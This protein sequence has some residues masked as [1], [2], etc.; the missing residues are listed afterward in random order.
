MNKL[1]AVSALVSTPCK[2]AFSFGTDYISANRKQIVAI[3]KFS[4]V[5]A[6]SV[7]VNVVGQKA[8]ILLLDHVRT[9]CVRTIQWPSINGLYNH[10]P[11]LCT[12][13]TELYL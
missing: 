2:P 7:T 3:Y 8:G 12:W 9:R 1:I 11:V 5:S 4:V 10:V 13:N 6:C